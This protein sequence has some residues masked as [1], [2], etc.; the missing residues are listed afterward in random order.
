MQVHIRKAR[1]IDP[2][3]AH[4]DK[5]TDLLVEDG[6]ITRIA[7]GIKTDNA[8]VIE[9]ADLCVSTGWVDTF[10]DYCEPG[11]EHKETIK[12]GLATAAAGGFTDVLI[13]P[14]TRPALTDRATIGYVQQKATGNVVNLHPIGAATRNADG[15]ELAEM[16]D[17]RTQGAIAF[18]DG[19]HPIQNPGLMMKA[20][21][22]VTAF[23]G[24]V[25]QLP[26]DAAL[27]QGGLM[28]EGPVSVALGMAGI[29]QLAETLM[30]YRD[31]ELAR[32]TR[33]RLHI[34]GI[35]TAASADMIR[36]AKA[37]GV[38]VTCSVTP[39][40]LALTDEAMRGYDSNYK[41]A[42]PLRTEADR[43]A[44][45]AALKDGTID[46]IGSHH[47]PHE[48]DAKQ[49]ELE[50]ASEGMAIQELAYNILWDS[51]R[52][53]IG[54]ERLVEALT[55][56]PRKIF[57]LRE[58]SIAKGA[59]ASLTLFTTTGNYTLA[60]GKGRSKGVNNPFAGQAL[61]GQVLGIINNNKVHINK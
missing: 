15:K 51:I 2:L 37:A 13:T 40:H 9:A 34:S 3:S 49:K 54:I 24:V 20:L 18:S 43:K 50:Y 57:G 35:T 39:Y 16:L 41:V 32:Y 59:Q 22:Y 4:H 45:V 42:P 7:T 36:K 48:W 12:S 6:V 10:A 38:N 30:V 55:T 17:M 25:M 52:K 61:A 23:N 33:S 19:W 56:T 26:V 1:V 8:T 11:Y 44:L 28:N 46:C 29:P 53:T 5:V 31:V 58:Q 27:S 21:E 14:N 47:H 60:A